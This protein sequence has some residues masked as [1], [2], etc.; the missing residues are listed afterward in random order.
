MTSELTLAGF[1]F[2]KAGHSESE[3]EDAGSFSD[4]RRRFAISDGAS[5]AYRSGLWSHLLATGFVDG[6]LD[7]S[8]DD[9]LATWLAERRERWAERNTVDGDTPFYVQ[10]ATERGSWATLLG[11]AIAPDHTWS[12]LAI[13]DSCLFHVRDDQLVS[14][15][16]IDRADAFDNHPPLV[17]TSGEGLDGMSPARA[18]GC[19]EPGDALVAVTDALAE[20]LLGEVGER[21]DVWR[22]LVTV[23]ESELGGMVVRSRRDD[24]MKNDD[25]T[26]VRCVRAPDRRRRRRRT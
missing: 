15:F 21:S 2:P 4:T 22:R 23:D 7:P 26:M 3:W 6:D 13:G 14:A 10:A 25:I 11:V 8:D 9:A 20:W 5:A 12:A 16:P 1:G 19:L 24:T 17:P 18:T